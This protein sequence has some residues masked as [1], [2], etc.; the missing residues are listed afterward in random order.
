MGFLRR[1][2]CHYDAAAAG[3]STLVG[4]MNDGRNLYGRHET[5]GVGPIDLDAC[6]GHTGRAV[7]SLHSRVSDS[8]RKACPLS[9]GA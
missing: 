4:I 5:T 8:L 2:V 9:S 7:A 6:G 3:H 1:R